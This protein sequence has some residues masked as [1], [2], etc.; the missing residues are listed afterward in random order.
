MF[1]F[2]WAG[3]MMKGAALTTGEEQ[4]IVNAHISRYNNVT[5]RMGKQGAFLKV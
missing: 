3:H 4:E 2:L 1:K 5:K